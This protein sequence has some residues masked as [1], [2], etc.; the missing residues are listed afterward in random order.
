MRLINL[1]LNPGEKG[2]EVPH[3]T[4]TPSVTSAVSSD[5]ECG[6]GGSEPR[7]CIQGVLDDGRTKRRWMSK[8]ICRLGGN[9]G[10]Q[11]VYFAR[12]RLMSPAMYGSTQWTTD[13]TRFNLL[14]LG[15]EYS[16]LEAMRGSCQPP[17]L[18]KPFPRSL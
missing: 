5:R 3:Y 18:A 4:K 1:C 8:C 16:V 10:E 9:Q 11:I 14:T 17:T 13:N 12:P 7:L 15:I 2:E 6:P